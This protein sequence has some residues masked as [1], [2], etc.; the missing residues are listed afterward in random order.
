MCEKRENRIIP[1]LVLCIIMLAFLFGPA[2]A[3]AKVT[4]GSIGYAENY[5]GLKWATKLGEGWQSS[6]TPPTVH[7]EYVYCA[8]TT[9]VVKLDKY[10][11][12]IV[13]SASLGK[14][15]KF[16]IIPIAYIEAD[17]ANGL[18]ED[19]IAVPL[20]DGKVRFFGAENLD[21]KY[22][23][24]ACEAAQKK[25]G[26]QLTTNI[27]YD[28]GYIYFGTWYGDTYDGYFY[29]YK[30]GDPSPVWTVT[31]PGG[32]YLSDAA[33]GE[34]HL[35]FGSDNGLASSN[36][37]KCTL[38][39]CK[40]GRAFEQEESEGS[41]QADP[42][43]NKIEDRMIGNCRAA[44]VYD[45]SSLFAATQAGKAYKF[46]LDSAGIP[47]L[48]CETD[49]GAATTGEATVYNGVIYYGL[50]NSMLV[51]LDTSDLSKIS[52]IP[53]PGYVQGGI[54]LSTAKEAEGE[55]YIY[56]SYNKEPAGLFAVKAS[57]DGVFGGSLMMFTPPQGMRQFNMTPISVDNDMVIYRNDSGN[58]MALEQGYTLWT[59]AGAGG[60][61]QR[62]CAAEA[63][64]SHS[65]AV[66]PNS[67]YKCVDIIVD[68]ASKGAAAS[69]TFEN[70]SGPHEL[71]AVF[72]QIAAPKIKT[73]TRSGYS[74][75][76]VSWDPAAG[77]NKYEVYRA[78]KAG[79]PYSKVAATA[80]CSYLD[81]GRTTGVRYYYK[82]K[83]I[84]ARGSVTSATDLSQAKWNNTILQKT[85]V[86]VTQ[87][88][89]RK[90]L[91]QWKKVPGATGYEVYRAAK[92]T[93]KYKRIVTIKKGTILKYTNKKLKKG[94]KYYYK[95]KAVRRANGKTARSAFSNISYC[96]VKK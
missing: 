58:I 32:F 8:K 3:N 49:L 78:T 73:V 89:G 46:D 20:Y 91:V 27:V 39:T 62:G 54:A 42:V 30:L 56:T 90:A 34:D 38:F 10:T 65:F 68:N 50:G 35:Y 67:G 7:G 11:G 36:G 37:G 57:T 94:K 31:K 76:S 53:T 6:P 86:K 60:S 4:G 43:V 82:I 2:R 52:S 72:M 88:K 19:L 33:I 22:T 77:A 70:V 45:G 55:L 40:K 87:K 26:I 47:Q 23:T 24:V 59:S 25:S 28:D 16:T 17:G 1:V 75:L 14:G 41:G 63:G 48:V 81:A 69:Y 9:E 84:Y 5:A 66:T 74:K 12:K 21:A 92:K 61:V 80:A 96:K 15:Q 51:S 79:G 13:R 71:K 95:V 85:K 29:C 18:T 44:V 64:S 93:G 83:G